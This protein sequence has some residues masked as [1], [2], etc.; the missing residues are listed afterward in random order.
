MWSC[1]D[2]ILF[3]DCGR[4]HDCWD[5][6]P[7]GA[8]S[9]LQNRC[10]KFGFAHPAE[11]EPVPI[12]DRGWPSSGFPQIAKGSEVCQ[13]KDGFN[14]RCIGAPGGNRILREAGENCRK[15]P[16]TRTEGGRLR[17]YYQPFDERHD[18][19]SG[20][21]VGRQSFLNCDCSMTATEI[22]KV[23][24]RDHLH[25]A[26]AGFAPF[27]LAFPIPPWHRF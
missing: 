6:A 22:R 12:F 5:F 11:S 7:A 20:E 27:A 13:S 9:S 10:Q 23:P 26:A 21:H 3:T 2:E 15:K 14:Q 8:A 19:S 18:N 17:A 24:R 25:R 16:A 4:H 1:G